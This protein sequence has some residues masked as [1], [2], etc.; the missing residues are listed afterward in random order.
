MP[1]SEQDG[2]GREHGLHVEMLGTNVLV[3]RPQGDDQQELR[4]AA[5]VPALPHSS[6]VLATTTALR[7]GGFLPALR[8][9]CRAV[10]AKS[11]SPHRIWIAVSGLSTP[12]PDGTPVAQQLADELGAD[13]VVPDG[14]LVRASGGTLFSGPQGSWDLFSR[15]T[16][17]RHFAH[18]YPTPAW[19]TALPKGAGSVSGITLEQIPAGLLA[20][21]ESAESARWGA[22]VSPSAHHPRILVEQGDSP[23]PIPPA[24][25]SS[26][27]TQ[28]HPAARGTVELVPATPR[29]LP[30][31][32]GPPL[33]AAL[34]QDVLLSTGFVLRGA[35]GDEHTVVR[36]ESSGESWEP[37]PRA[38]RCSADGTI[39]VVAAAAPPPGWTLA[40]PLA[41]QP[42]EQA[43][44]V[45]ARV[46]PAGLALSPGVPTA[47]TAADQ[48]RFEPHQMSVVIGD[49]SV[50]VPAGVPQ[51]LRL[52][53]R[54]LEPQR[55]T[56]CRLIV[57]GTI[58]V[59]MRDELVT[60]AG[61]LA[62]RLRFLE[63]PQRRAATSAANPPGAA[64]ASP[65]QPASPAPPATPAPP[66]TPAPAGPLPPLPASR[67]ATVSE[68]PAELVANA[69]PAPAEPP[70]SLAKP[71]STEKT[72]LSEKDTPRPAS[73]DVVPA[74]LDEHSVDPNHDSTPEER[75]RFAEAAGSEFD[76]FLPSVNSA[77]ASFPAL[78]EGLSE[79]SGQDTK[80]DF[81]AV[82]LYLG[83]NGFGA[84]ET[85]RVLRTNEPEP[86]RDY[87]DYTACLTSGLR[88]LPVHRGAAF[89]L[90][91]RQADPVYTVGEVL[92][93]PGFLSASTES[94]LTC[95]QE[96][97]DVVI[98]SNSARRTS[99]FHRNGL[100]GEVVFTAATRFKVLETDDDEGAPA[101]LM[102]EL[103]TGEETTAGLLDEADE[104]VLPR[105]RRALARR[106]AGEL[107][108]LDDPDQQLR[109]A[110]PVGLIPA[111]QS[112]NQQAQNQQ[113]GNQ[114]PSYQQPG[115]PGKGGQQPGDNQ[116]KQPPGTVP[117][118]LTT[119][120]GG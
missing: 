114:Q 43:S 108:V 68:P 103:R 27:V 52:L 26:L 14:P 89:R 15:G 87:R 16:R 25:L 21:P 28:L 77:L 117:R 102:R 115:Y 19:E 101:V 42:A 66:V 105:L 31:G 97:L 120:S 34:G 23:R 116:S 17:T 55:R 5:S 65:A 18:R 113:P 35:G 49:P 110:D 9:A 7:D 36:D 90:A 75:A 74:T 92:S 10:T 69:A 40:G 99:P 119:T 96:H 61:D 2:A 85:N 41:Y 94:D 48:L 83:R 104:A 53:L 109:L 67:P 81:V 38:L 91:R 3:R 29:A 12:G 24:A 88:R 54:A 20:R 76:D 56:R 47:P 118:G 39:R 13:L 59:G 57:L 46:V 11:T 70:S 30:A 44:T 37:F 64:P 71:P 93:E 100:A 51:A 72:P 78:R 63:E 82:C 79:P 6:A 33:A 8:E 98:W 50:P 80:A 22:T 45:I 73:S 86:A 32:Q 106:R 4:Y 58:D 1:A 62:E 111:Q 60:A 107:R 95:E 112:N 84:N